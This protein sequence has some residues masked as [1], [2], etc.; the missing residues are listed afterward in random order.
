MNQSN[1]HAPQP[2]ALR[3]AGTEISKGPRRPPPKKRKGNVEKRGGLP[4]VV[5][6][7]ELVREFA[8]VTRYLPSSNETKAR[9][10][11]VHVV[12]AC[13]GAQIFPEEDVWHQVGTWTSRLRGMK[14]IEGVTKYH[15]GQAAAQKVLNSMRRA[16]HD[17]ALNHKLKSHIARFIRSALQSLNS[18]LT[19]LLNADSSYALTPDEMMNMVPFTGD[20][21]HH[22][23]KKPKTKSRVVTPE[24]N[25]TQDVPKTPDLESANQV[26][27][28]KEEDQGIS[29]VKRGLL[30]VKNFFKS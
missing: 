1:R 29:I 23:F 11:L 24:A 12:M 28:E 5:V 17:P 9:I 27:V 20:Q 13:P 7:E 18:Q 14:E 30:K 16:E 19:S 2:A 15:H 4:P 25:K 26:V 8:L 10:A 22:L 21:S 6:P 3:H